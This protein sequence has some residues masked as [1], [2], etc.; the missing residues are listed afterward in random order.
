M[1]RQG[2]LGGVQ[3][4]SYRGSELFAW[5][6][7]ARMMRCRIASGDGPN[8]CSGKHGSSTVRLGKCCRPVTWSDLNSCFHMTRSSRFDRSVKAGGLAK[9]AAW[10]N[11]TRWLG[12]RC[13]LADYPKACP[14]QWIRG[15][16]L[17][18][19]GYANSILRSYNRNLPIWDENVRSYNPTGWLLLLVS[20]YECNDFRC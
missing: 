2:I 5:K 8:R 4:A 13:Q 6:Y 3:S 10:L 20:W 9:V 18:Q 16:N 12:R 14:M 11:R 1:R 15:K 19:T 7:C 17:R